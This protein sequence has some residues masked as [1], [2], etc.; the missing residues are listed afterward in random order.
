MKKISEEKAEAEPII[1]EDLPVL[2]PVAPVKLSEEP[3]KEQIDIFDKDI[4]DIP[5]FIDSMSKND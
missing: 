3:Q 2:E 4:L 1:E 5:S